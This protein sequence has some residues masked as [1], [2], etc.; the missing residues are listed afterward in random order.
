MA[1]FDCSTGVL[2]TS[3]LIAVIVPGLNV[4]SRS[5]SRESQPPMTSSVLLATAGIADR[6]DRLADARL[7]GV[8]ESERRQVL[9]GRS[10]AA[11]DPSR[12]D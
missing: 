9:A 5:L 8:A 2:A 7:F 6:Q 4:A 3:R 1:T 10:A 11:P 12:A